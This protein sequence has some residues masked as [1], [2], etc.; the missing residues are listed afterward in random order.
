MSRGF[1]LDECSSH[2]S[3]SHF[4]SILCRGLVNDSP[5]HFSLI[6]ICCELSSLD[7][8]LSDG[9]ELFHYH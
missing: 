2:A 9:G 3:Q 6:L 4:N 5:Y 1:V 7:G 8:L